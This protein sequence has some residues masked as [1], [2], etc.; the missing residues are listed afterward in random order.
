VPPIVR[1]G[2]AQKPRTA[3]EIRGKTV[4]RIEREGEAVVFY[5]TE[6]GFS[7]SLAGSA[8]VPEVVVDSWISMNDTEGNMNAPCVER[9]DNNI[10]ISRAAANRIED[11]FT[12]TSC[13][14][15]SAGNPSLTRKYPV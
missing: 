10:S 1:G 14:A 4:D 11:P 2:D 5:F 3:R 13:S 9:P 8:P 6:S 7:S 12:A 15:F